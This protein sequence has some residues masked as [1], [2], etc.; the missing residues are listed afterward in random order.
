MSDETL[1]KKL[2]NPKQARQE[3]LERARSQ[4]GRFRF[5]VAG[6][7][8]LVTV[9]VT[10]GILLFSKHRADNISSALD[11][12]QLKG[13]MVDAEFNPSAGRVRQVQISEG[14]ERNVSA[15][16]LGS[17]L[18]IISRVNYQSLTPKNYEVIGTAPW[19]LLTNV[20]VNADDPALL[21][22]LF[23]NDSMIKAFMARPAV[24]AALEDPKALAA[25]AA[26]EA[27]LNGFFNEDAVKQVL[28]NDKLLSTFSSSR[29]LAFLLISKSV[30]YYRDNPGRALKIIDASPTL[31]AL[32][33]NPAVRREI[34]KNRYLKN[35]AP[36]LL[37]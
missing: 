37:K 7:L 12:A 16:E 29:F 15:R 36:I 19:G 27:L 20:S 8:A 30:K 17:T 26:D 1:L 31:T 13:L 6:T 32:K 21:G 14:Q 5:A 28:K 34:Q 23:S 9:V 22:F 33:K 2:R 11:P 24:A 10:V 18:P 25:I 4:Q 3:T 35:I